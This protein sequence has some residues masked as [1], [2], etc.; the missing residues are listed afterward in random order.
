MGAKISKCSDHRAGANKKVI[1]KAC[2][3]SGL[4]Q[5]LKNNLLAAV[6]VFQSYG[7]KE[8]EEKNAFILKHGV[9]AWLLQQAKA[10]SY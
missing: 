9:N 8:R 7:I 1:N 2:Q 5:V 3:L 10:S 4:E 6:T